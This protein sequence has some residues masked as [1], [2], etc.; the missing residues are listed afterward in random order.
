MSIL[1]HPR[2]LVLDL[3]RQTSPGTEG[4]VSKALEG[5]GNLVGM[6]RH[7]GIRFCALWLR[8]LLI[9]IAGGIEMPLGVST[10]KTRKSIDLHRSLKLFLVLG[11]AFL[12]SLG[13]FL[14]SAEAAGITYVQGNFAVPATAQSSLSV[15]YAAAQTAGDLNVVVVGWTDSTTTISS[16]TDSNGNVYALAAGP[17]VQAGVQT[18]SIYYAKKIAAAVA[19]GNSVTVKFSASA[20]Y[21][22]IRILEYS[23]LDTVNPLDV[24]IGASGSGSTAG[25]GSVTTTTANDLLIGADI[26]TSITSGPGAGYTKRILTSPNGDIAE[27]RIVTAAGSYS[28]S[29]SMTSGKYVMQMVA[30]RAAGAGTPDA[31]PPSVPSNLTANAGSSTQIN[32][33]WTASTDPDSPVSGYPVER[34]QGTSCTNFV[35][36]GIPTTNSYSDT[37]LTASTTYTYRVRAT[38]PSNNLSGY[39]NT[40]SATTQT[41]PPP[42]PASITYVQGNYAVPSTSQSTVTLSYAAAQTAGNFNIVIVGWTN[43][44]STVSSV[45]DSSGNVYALAIGPTVQSGVQS[46]SIYYA[47]NI[48]AAIAGGNAVTVKFNTATPYIDIRM[49][50]YSG[51]DTANP[52]DAA[53]GAS[54]NGTLASA[55][56]LA[57]INANDLLIGADIVTSVT[58]GAGAGYA[59]RVL[60]SPNGDIAEDEV[61]ASTGSYTAT[62][63]LS[64]GQWVM[65]IAA[66]KQAGSSGTADTTPPVVNITAPAA[67]AKVT[68]TV[69]VSATATD[70]DSPVAGVQFMVD[71]NDIGAEVTSGPFSV[72]WDSTTSTNG[73]HTLTALARD[74]SNNRATSPGITVAVQNTAPPPP[75]VT[76]A[77]VQKNYAVP[78]TPQ[79]AVSANFIQAQNAGDV[80]VVVIGWNDTTASVTSVTDTMANTYAVAAGPTVQSGI[81]SQLIYYAK[82]ISASQANFNAVTV[83]FSV[84]AAYPD[85][86]ILEYSGLDNTTTIDVS[87]GTSGLGLIADSGSVNTLNAKDL[88]FGANY[89]Q[90]ST[91]SAGPGFTSEVITSP[92]GDIAEDEVVTTTGSHNAT[93][94]LSSSGNWIMQMVAFRAA[95]SPPA[96]P[97][98]TTPPVVSIT[99]PASNTTVTGTITI[100]VTAADPDSPVASVQLLDNGLNFGAALTTAPYNF[101]VDTTTFYNG[102]HT[103]TAVAV[104]PSNNT[105]TSAAVT[106]IVAN[107]SPKPTGQWSGPYSWP[108]VGIHAS[109]MA[110]GKV[111]TWEDET[112][113]PASSVWDPLTNTF[114]PVPYTSQD[115]F[116]SGH[117]EL[118][119]GRILVGGGHITNY[120]GINNS[121]LFD[122][123]AQTWSSAP[124][125]SYARWYPTLTLLPDGRALITSG[126]INCD[127]CNADTPEVYDPTA[128]TWTKLTGAT[129]H[130]PIYPHMFVLPDGRVLNSGS[131]ELPT[132]ARVLDVNAQT[133]TTVDSHSYDG[134]S[135]VM[136]LPGKILKSG[137]SATSDAPYTNSAS[138]AYVL[139]MTQSSPAWRTTTS[140]AYA[141]TYHNLTS[142]PDGTV[143]ATG[144]ELTTD[145]FDQTQG[146]YAA[147]LWSPTTEKWTT[148]ASMQI[149]R[150]YHSTALLLPDGRVLS[151]GSG[152]YGSGSTDQRNAEIYSPP[153]LF[154]G[155]RPVITSAPSTLQYGHPFTVQT[156]NASTIASV[157]LIRLGSVTHG[158]N[159]NQRFL[160]LTFTAGSGNLSV[161]APAN[162][163]LAP[164]GYYMLF[165]VDTNGVPSVAAILQ[166]P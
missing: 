130:L 103:L 64:S 26:V 97:P 155:P 23:G 74:P 132:P 140:M 148:M 54:G 128:N 146:V 25:S 145:P 33:A 99:S 67:N 107:S 113:N 164:P 94:N 114:T 95:G 21:I 14:T 124:L 24:S 41:A 40:S 141:R 150:V 84:A 3:P 35:Q 77:F 100:K 73:T 98:D 29:A 28:A 13:P 110:N 151:A 108:L 31:T 72:A 9:F 154:K 101:T 37:G 89:V 102:P 158:F 112:T 92:D 133:W 56:P 81:Q 121:T 162:A 49:L 68:G 93:A 63:S 36:I 76:P 48:T 16:V 58:S 12:P 57:T 131:Y 60:S 69:T 75:P 123:V 138:T 82:N 32:L 106:I 85:V 79:S 163:N 125:L 70:P 87:A 30:F 2:L 96:G 149:E 46:Q 18:Q 44:T 135:A 45:T 165:L 6:Q 122:P 105:G 86:R 19:G 152:E 7:R 34:C 66:F 156:P 50:E 8:R 142:L 90:T 5:A 147:E 65:Q 11:A 139:D 88:L 126:A 118:R 62:A 127:G 129:L 143:L 43:S 4:L 38:D 116:C 159:Q 91:A 59:K 166:F 15:T 1:T 20:P 78:S 137:T 55:G 161:T 104:D 115:L 134:G 22:D 71:N 10:S 51:L 47:K 144:G 120:V 17:T 153:Y 39:S 117:T 27:D 61:V 53:L 42:P 157:S 80:N 109:L 83:H 111:L 52:F 119:D 160:P 136:Y